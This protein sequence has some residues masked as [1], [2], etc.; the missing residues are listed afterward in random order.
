MDGRWP[1]LK[2]RFLEGA[3]LWEPPFAGVSTGSGP[4]TRGLYAAANPRLQRRPGWNTCVRTGAEGLSG[5]NWMVVRV[6]SGTPGMPLRPGAS[7]APS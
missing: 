4:S 7:C 6:S 3:A 1:H 2:P 5:G